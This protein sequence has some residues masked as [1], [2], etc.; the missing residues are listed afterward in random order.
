MASRI[1]FEGTETL[2][3]GTD[4]P[5]SRLT[6]V[7]I[8]TLILV[9]IPSRTA[10]DTLNNWADAVSYTY[11]APPGP[12][13][14]SV[15]DKF[16]R[17]GSINGN[18]LSLRDGLQV[19]VGPFGPLYIAISD[20]GTYLDDAQAIRIGM[21]FTDDLNAWSDFPG[22]VPTTYTNVADTL[23]SWSDAALTR[24]FGHLVT[25]GLTDA[26]TLSDVF[27]AI[28]PNVAIIG[29]PLSFADSFA[30]SLVSEN[31]FTD[32]I[33]LSESTRIVLHSQ[34]AFSDALTLTDGTVNSYSIELESAVSDDLNL[35][36][37]T[38]EYTSV[39]GEVG[40]LRQY[41]N[42]MRY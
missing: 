8:E 6:F 7:A 11:L 26:L 34:V 16:I 24:F 41:L 3:Q 23:N 28:L 36:A 17:N 31:I 35:W 37:D 25:S 21:L 22:S 4:T 1:T 39:L 12:L 15:E 2:L 14:R 27:S 33:T 10:S 19:H 18:N 32:S 20:L 13:S 9:I 40:Y 42:D 38:F 30:S 29:D 5:K